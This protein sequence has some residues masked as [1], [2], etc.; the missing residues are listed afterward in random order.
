MYCPIH[1]AN[2]QHNYCYYGNDFVIQSIHEVFPSSSELFTS[3]DIEPTCDYISCY[4]I[5][6]TSTVSL[7]YVFYI[8]L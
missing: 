2:Y 3:D 4:D 5:S 1:Q 6:C 7:K 8:I